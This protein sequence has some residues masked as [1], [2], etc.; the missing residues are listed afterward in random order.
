MA[1]NQ[2][3]DAIVTQT[4]AK[5]AADLV[6]SL[7]QENIESA[8]KDWEEAFAVVNDSIF[9][10][11]GLSNQKEPWPVTGGRDIP[12]VKNRE[13]IVQSI[14]QV[15]EGRPVSS[16]KQAPAVEVAGK[17]H[18][19]IPAWL[20]RAA[21]KAGVTKVWDN[22]DAL[23]DNPKRPHFVSAD[24]NKTPFWPPKNLTTDEIPFGV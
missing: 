5:I 18:G 11:I 20:N 9:S 1:M 8:L 17:Q 22:R 24:A 14:Q 19:D 16:M 21:S 7:K 23:K 4:A 13:E 12:V 15:K 6:A 3:N 10:K 2:V